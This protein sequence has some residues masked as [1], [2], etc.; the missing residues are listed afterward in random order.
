MATIYLT[1]G[2][3]GSGKDRYYSF[4]KAANRSMIHVS[5]DLIREEVFGDINDQTHNKQV[6]EI[7]EKRTI[8]ALNKGLDVYY[9]ATNVESRR[10]IAFLSKMPIGTIKVAILITPPLYVVKEQNLRRPRHVPDH[11]IDRMFKIFC[12]PD[13][14]EGF[15]KI[16]H[17]KDCIH[18]FEDEIP[19]N[20]LD[21]A[22][23]IPHDN[24]HHTFTIGKHM[25]AAHQYFLENKKEKLSET[26]DED[27]LISL[28]KAILFHD[29]A[30]PYCKSFTNS[31]GIITPEAHYYSHANA[32]A[33]VFLSTCNTP[34]SLYSALLINH[35]M[36]GFNGE[37]Q[38][39]HLNKFYGDEFFEDLMILNECDKAAH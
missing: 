8:E 20:M 3:P 33:Y 38:L 31:K 14:A 15:D 16:I 18:F 10:R 19:M 1:I 26:Y 35:H 5:S 11:V 28:E 13:Y 7:M 23:F 22:D 37:K 9:N 6:F 36:A 30:K 17:V 2:L 34:N 32:S 39:S 27:R 12:V 29:I 4:L 21:I 25:R 24:E